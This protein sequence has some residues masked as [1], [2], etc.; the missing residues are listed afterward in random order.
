MPVAIYKLRIR[1]RPGDDSAWQEARVVAAGVAEALV[2]AQQRFGEEYVMGIEQDTGEPVPE[3]EAADAAIDAPAPA[4]ALAGDIGF[5]SG[6]A[7]REPMPWEGRWRPSVLVWTG[8]G[9]GVLLFALWVQFG[10]SGRDRFVTASDAPVAPASGLALDHS[11]PTGGVLAATGLRVRPGQRGNAGMEVVD[12][13][14]AEFSEAADVDED[15]A[16]Q[17]R[18]IGNLV[19]DMF[20]RYPDEPASPPDTPASPPDAPPPLSTNEPSVLRPFY[21]EVERGDGSVE[22]LRVTAS[23]AVHARAIVGG[24]PERPVIL[25]GPSPQLDW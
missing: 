25:R 22:T 16:N 21:V 15:T 13:A 3:D 20:S 12:E 14:V 18:D 10:E 4:L 8:V 5:H 7:P 23:D 9:A 19:G 24:L 11:A 6:D 17:V 2:Q 1:D